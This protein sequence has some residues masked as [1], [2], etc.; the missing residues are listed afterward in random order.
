MHHLFWPKNW[1]QD[2][3]TEQEFRELQINRVPMCEYEEKRL[4][5]ETSPPPKPTFTVME[6]VVRM[7]RERQRLAGRDIRKP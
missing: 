7:Q 4:H 5:E 2:N 3:E 1:Y 6:A